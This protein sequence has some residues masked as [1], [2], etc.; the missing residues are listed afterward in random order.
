[1]KSSFLIF[2]ACALNHSAISP[3]DYCKRLTDFEM[4]FH[5]LILLL[6]KS[7]IARHKNP[8]KKRRLQ[9]TIPSCSIA[10]LFLTNKGSGQVDSPLLTGDGPFP[11]SATKVFS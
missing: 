6:R 4:R 1:V 10:H 3:T 8:A 11:K 9:I 7:Q 5:F 2:Q